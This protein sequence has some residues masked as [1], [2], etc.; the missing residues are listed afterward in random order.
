MRDT[1]AE[2]VVCDVAPPSASGVGGADGEHIAAVD[3]DTAG[4]GVA[5]SVSMVAMP[6]IVCVGG[7]GM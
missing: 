3:D 7:R 6:V 4:G 2:R 1:V 5:L